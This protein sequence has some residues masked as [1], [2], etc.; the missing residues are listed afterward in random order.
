MC[1]AF[2][3]KVKIPIKDRTTFN[4]MLQ[5][6]IAFS[7]AYPTI[8]T[9]LPCVAPFWIELLAQSR[10]SYVR[11]KNDF[12]RSR[13]EP[14]Y[15]S[16]RVRICLIYNERNIMT[17][18]LFQIKV[19]FQCVW[20]PACVCLQTRRYP[21]L[22]KFVWISYS[23]TGTKVKRSYVFPDHARKSHKYSSKNS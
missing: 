10:L 2:A 12:V 23:L 19:W 20:M 22:F 6:K 16:N 8:Q 3:L 4:C 21:R 9:R 15:L 13:I 18:K 11:I 1:N 7:C 5:S 14:N 17:F